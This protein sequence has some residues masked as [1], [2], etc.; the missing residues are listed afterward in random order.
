ML[1]YVGRGLWKIRHKRGKINKHIYNISILNNILNLLKICYFFYE[2]VWMAVPSIGGEWRSQGCF[3]WSNRLLNKT[4]STACG[5]FAY[6]LMIRQVL[7]VA[8]TLQGILLVLACP[9]ELDGNILLMTKTKYFVHR[10]HGDIELELSWKHSYCWLV[11]TV[12]EGAMLT[13]REEKSLKV[14]L[15]GSTVCYNSDNPRMMCP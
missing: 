2:R 11:C 13:A 1:V 15:P 12:L 8:N 10:I 3:S 9:L 14:Y 5:I 4:Q 6:K 7:E